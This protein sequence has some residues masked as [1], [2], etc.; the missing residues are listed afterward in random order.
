M[1]IL[2]ESLLLNDL[3][4]TLDSASEERVLIMRNEKK[5]MV[6]MSMDEYNGL[7]AEAYQAEKK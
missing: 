3:T 2:K 1:K 6:I 7:K 4:S 5:P